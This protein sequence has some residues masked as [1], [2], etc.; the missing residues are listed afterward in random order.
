[1]CING[2]ASRPWALRMPALSNQIEL[3]IQIK[4]ILSFIIVFLYEVWLQK[5]E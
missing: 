1:M 4:I 3:K 2:H 5:T